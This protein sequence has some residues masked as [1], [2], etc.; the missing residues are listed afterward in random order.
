[1]RMTAH[2]KPHHEPPPIVTISFTN[3]CSL[4]CIHCYSD[5]NSAPSR[6]ELGTRQW[7]GF[8]DY[9]DDHN[10]SGVY[11][12]G[13]DPLRRGD[14]LEVLR[15]SSRSMMTW[16]RTNATLVD[17]AA[18]RQLRQSGLGGAFVDLMGAT[19]RTHEL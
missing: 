8:V 10:F 6:Q 14:F 5:C 2:M 12:E 16:L 1:M 3:T 11:F 19:R 9:L 13:G 17:R 4:G 15:Y 18:S 7:L